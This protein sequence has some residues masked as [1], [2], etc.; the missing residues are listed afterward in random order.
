MGPDAPRLW[1]HLALVRARARADGRRGRARRSCQ[2]RHAAWQTERVQTERVQTETVQ[3]DRPGWPGRSRPALSFVLFQAR[4]L[5]ARLRQSRP[6]RRRHRPLRPPQHQRNVRRRLSLPPPQALSPQQHG[7]PRPGIAACHRTDAAGRG[8][9]RPLSLHAGPRGTSWSGRPDSCDQPDPCDETVRLARK[10]QLRF[11]PGPCRLARSR[12]P[13]RPIR[14]HATD[15]FLNATDPCSRIKRS[16]VETLMG[17]REQMSD[18][19][20]EAMLIVL[21]G[22]VQASRT[23]LL[24]R[25]SYRPPVDLAA[26]PFEPPSS[27]TPTALQK[28]RCGKCGSG[29][30]FRERCLIGRQDEGGDRLGLL[31]GL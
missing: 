30:R 24:P 22:P 12:C 14:R 17:S 23:K 5:T 2:S 19:P 16:P 21:P 18:C 6:P 3:Q 10:R 9:S 20:K 26:R 27:R 8:R 29:T 31:R 25:H 28:M 15:P 7:P 1:S 11:R 4:R 13:P